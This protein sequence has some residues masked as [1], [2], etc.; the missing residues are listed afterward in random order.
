MNWWFHQFFMFYSV[1]GCSGKKIKNGCATTTH[2]VQSGVWFCIMLYLGPLSRGSFTMKQLWAWSF[3]EK[4]R[5]CCATEISTVNQLSCSCLATCNTV[6]WTSFETNNF[7]GDPVTQERIT[8]HKFWTAY[9]FRLLY[10][11]L[12]NE[13]TAKAL[14]KCWGTTCI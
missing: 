14:S 5:A 6:P 8:R 12:V 10:G 3:I 4:T 9:N 1:R 2:C 7:G 13:S 11:S